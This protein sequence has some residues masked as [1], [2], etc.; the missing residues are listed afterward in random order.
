LTTPSGVFRTL[1]LFLTLF[2]N[3]PGQVINIF[4]GRLYVYPGPQTLTTG[5]MTCFFLYAQA[6]F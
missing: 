2:G 5:I 3:K 4:H 6:W 1:C